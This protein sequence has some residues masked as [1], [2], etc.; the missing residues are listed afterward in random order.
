[1]Y[2][3]HIFFRMSRE[4]ER[5]GAVGLYYISRGRYDPCCNKGVDSS[6]LRTI[7]VSVYQGEDKM[8][9]RTRVLFY[10]F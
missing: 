8:P 7:F 10:L 5:E 2:K 1:M 6:V 9:S 4:R 3:C